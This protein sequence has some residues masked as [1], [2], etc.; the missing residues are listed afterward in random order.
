MEADQQPAQG[1][2][3]GVVHQ[4]CDE[5]VSGKQPHQR[6]DVGATGFG[7]TRMRQDFFSGLA[8]HCLYRCR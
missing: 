8:L 6:I 4:P 7:E 3:A 1:D 2:G 5:A